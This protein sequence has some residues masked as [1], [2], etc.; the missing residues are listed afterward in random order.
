MPSPEKSTKKKASASTRRTHRAEVQKENISAIIELL[1]KKT[2]VDFGRYKMNTIVRRI[3]R[4]MSMQKC[5]SLNEFAELLRAKPQKVTELYNDIFIHV[6]EFVRDEDAFEYLRKKII[7]LIYKG[8]KDG[9]KIRIWVAGC[10]TGE[11]VYSL[12]IYF[13]EYLESRKMQLGLHF[14][15]TDI[16]ESA[17]RKARQGV[18]PHKSVMKLGKRLVAKYFDEVPEGYRIGEKIRD[19]CIFSQHDLTQDPPFSQLDFIS[20]RNVFIYFAQDLQKEVLSLYSRALVDEGILWLGPSESPSQLAKQFTT[21]D[22][23]TKFFQKKVTT[24]ED[25]P[26]ETSMKRN[27]P[28]LPLSKKICSGIGKNNKDLSFKELLKKITKQESQM[29]DILEEFEAYR[30]ELMATNEEL[31]ASNEE[32][33][34]TNEELDTTQEELRCTNEELITINQEL[35]DRNQQLHI[36]ND[37][38]SKSEERFR[39]IVNGVRDYAIFMLDPE[40]WIISWNKGAE[41]IKGY[42]SK[43]I[44]GSHFSRFYMPEDLARHQPQNELKIASEVGSYEEEG[45]RVRKDGSKFWAHV[46]ITRM[47]DEN[48]RLIGFSK[49]TRDLTDKRKAEEE[50]RRSEERFRLMV[51]SVRDYAIFMLDPEGRIISWNEGA[52]RAK[53]YS[54]EEILGSHFSRFYLPEDV[55]RNH[56]QKELEIAKETGS[57]EEEGWRVRKDGTTFWANVIISRVND[58]A[59][60]LIGFAKITRDLTERMRTEEKLRRSHQ[61]L[62]QKVL[63]RTQELESALKIRDEFLSIASH[64]LKTPL[65]SLKLQM[66]LSRRRLKG[67]EETPEQTQIAASVDKALKQVDSL[68]RLVEDLLDVSRIQTGTFYL[69]P[70]VMDISELME[71]LI[72]RYSPQLII[73]GCDVAMD[74][75][76]NLLG[77]WDRSRLEQVIAN[78]IS[79][80]IKYAP[81]APLKITAKK[82]GDQAEIIVAD[83]GPGILPDDQEKIFERF[84]RVQS[85]NQV[86]GLGLGLF[87]TRKIV[88]AHEG[89]IHVESGPNAGA[90]FVIRLPL[91]T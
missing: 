69:D 85:D 44:L 45:W 62:E 63:E 71:D 54:E 20:C 48:D 74:L 77:R 75:E 76:D 57:Y 53:G 22:K 83:Q 49:V 50:L 64:E 43:E 80:A 21:L 8:K 41:R 1:Q 35:E 42:S 39:L 17:I 7:P 24:K 52:R 4:Q 31:H 60:N 79:N 72:Q 5:N 38:L 56:P 82:V 6:T 67:L 11:E 86:G 90:R 68:G 66:Q 23:K 84:E 65:T 73:S 37:E 13:S 12:A 18:Y 81:G 27:L 46:L 89:T 9:E 2:G 58:S 61:S 78:L 19:L 26:Q 59:G 16:S 36:L 15:A 30:E 14:L 55:A 25:T 32:L 40:G 33:Q 51:N 87:I 3:E 47:T 88:E 29:E 91:R 10:A 28:K 34:S 70:E